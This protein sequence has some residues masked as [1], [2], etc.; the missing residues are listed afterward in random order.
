MLATYFSFDGCSLA[1]NLMMMRGEM[2]VRGDMEGVLI[3]HISQKAAGGC[4]LYCIVIQYIVQV[5]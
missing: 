1:R 5:V 4:M 3:W 2:D